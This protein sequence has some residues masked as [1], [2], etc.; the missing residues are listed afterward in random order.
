MTL[1]KQI[2]LAITMLDDTRQ[3]LH[4]L[5]VKMRTKSDALEE[6]L[7]ELRAALDKKETLNHTPKF[8]DSY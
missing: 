2:E 3:E 6:L 7:Q 1:K 4:A 5:V 8:P